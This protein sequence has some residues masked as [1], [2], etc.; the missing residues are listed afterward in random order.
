LHY[1]APMTFA[2]FSAFEKRMKSVD[3]TRAPIVDRLCEELARRFAA[4]G[5]KADTG[6]HLRQPTRANRFVKT[7]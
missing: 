6:V 5:C 3:P 2:D 1:D 7:I 4:A